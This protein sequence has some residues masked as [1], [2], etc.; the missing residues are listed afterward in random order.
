MRDWFEMSLPEIDSL[1]ASAVEF[2]ALGARLTG[3]GFGGCIVACLETGQR[4][5]WL[6]K[7]IK[8]HPDA[9]FIDSVSA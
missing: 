9:R 3:G 5:A 8:R 2:G 7:L 4:E 1:V 6:T